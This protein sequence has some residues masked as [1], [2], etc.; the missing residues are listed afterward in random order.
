MTGRKGRFWSCRYG[1]LEAPLQFSWWCHRPPTFRVGHDICRGRIFCWRFCWVV[2]KIYP[3][4]CCCF[5]LGGEGFF[6]GW[7]LKCSENILHFL[8]KYDQRYGKTWKI[9]SFQQKNIGNQRIFKAQKHPETWHMG[10]ISLIMNG[11]ASSPIINIIITIFFI[12]IYV[13]LYIWVFPKL[14][15]PPNYEF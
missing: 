12:W 14:R 1:P 7:L 6:V 13:L 10:W 15:V 5:C 4:I 9:W 3:K 8:K 11:C 2:V